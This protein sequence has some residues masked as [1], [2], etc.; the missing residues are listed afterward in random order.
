MNDAHF[1]KNVQNN[2]RNAMRVSLL[3]FFEKS[4]HQTIHPTQ[5]ALLKCKI[6]KAGMK[7]NWKEEHLSSDQAHICKMCFVFSF[8][9]SSF[10]RTVCAS[11]VDFADAFST[12]WNFICRKT[13]FLCVLKLKLKKESRFNN[14]IWKWNIY[15]FTFI[16]NRRMFRILKKIR[17]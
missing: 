10:C 16:F 9:K 7:L 4:K 12:S 1:L 13:I 5:C 17:K 2:V 14:P 15:I 8:K 11:C 6:P 3:L